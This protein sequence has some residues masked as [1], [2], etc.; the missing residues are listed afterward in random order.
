MPVRRHG[1][2]ANAQARYNRPQEFKYS[3]SIKK[4]VL[5]KLVIF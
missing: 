5:W 3:F 1:H 2:A 4:G